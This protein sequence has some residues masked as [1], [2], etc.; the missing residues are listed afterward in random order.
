MKVWNSESRE[1]NAEEID[2]LQSDGDRR[3]QECQSACS[4][5]C[6]DVLAPLEF[7][8]YVTKGMGERAR[9]REL[10]E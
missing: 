1:Y 8:A 5:K 4:R 10:R 2:N 7:M 6:R 3:N 9:D